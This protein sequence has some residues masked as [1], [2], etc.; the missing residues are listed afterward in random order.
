MNNKYT[1]KVEHPLVRSG[2]TIETEASEKY[3]VPV[4]GK[5]MDLVREFNQKQDTNDKQSDKQTK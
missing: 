2:V 4:L 1:I 5:T 3:V